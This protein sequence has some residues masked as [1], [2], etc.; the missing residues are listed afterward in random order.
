M[1][2]PL[3]HFFM[4]GVFCI[5][6]IFSAYNL[7]KSLIIAF[8]VIL[9]PFNLIGSIAYLILGGGILLQHSKS[10]KATFLAMLPSTIKILLYER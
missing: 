5:G 4:W 6:V 10:V 2:N 9:N 8:Q 3:K 7:T 1:E